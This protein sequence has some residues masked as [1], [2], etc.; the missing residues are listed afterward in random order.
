MPRGVDKPTDLQ[1]NDAMEEMLFNAFLEQHKRG[2]RADMGWKAE[3]WVFVTQ[4][5]QTIYQ[6][7]LVISK[8]QCQT[9]ESTY[10]SH[11]RDH[12]FIAGLSG[13]SWNQ[14]LGV[15]EAPTEAWD[16]LIKVFHHLAWQL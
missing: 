1:W 4:A 13:F 9:K 5:V 15:F 8:K 6:G 11:F 10:K 16:E 14:E 7:P 3:A 12:L 2:K